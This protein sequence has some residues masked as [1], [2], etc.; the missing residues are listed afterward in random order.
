MLKIN[1]ITEIGATFF[2]KSINEKPREVPIITFGGSPTI[3][4]EPPIFDETIS[5]KT[6]GTG[7][8]SNIFETSI[9][10]EDI[11]IMTVILSINADKMAVKKDK[12]TNKSKIFFPKILTTLFPKILKKF[13]SFNVITRVNIPKSNVIA[14]QL[15]NESASCG[16][17]ILNKTRID[18]AKKTIIVLGRSSKIIKR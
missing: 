18:E 7:L 16:V 15:T 8:N 13:T 17:T 10:K 5:D 12:T 4:A 9:V 1:T 2:K 11:N 6:K 14:S 3:V